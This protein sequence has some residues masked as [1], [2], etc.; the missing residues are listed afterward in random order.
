MDAI[1]ESCGSEFEVDEVDWTYGED[2]T[3]PSC[4]EVNGLQDGDA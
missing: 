2:V 4:G 1:C 3:C